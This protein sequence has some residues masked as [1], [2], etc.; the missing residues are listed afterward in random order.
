MFVGNWSV[1]EDPALLGKRWLKGT[2]R[3]KNA[4]KSGMIAFSDRIAGDPVGSRFRG[5]G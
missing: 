2:F 1:D 4:K 5:G 3:G